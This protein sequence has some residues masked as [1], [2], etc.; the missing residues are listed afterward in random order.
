MLFV[1][2]P[3][4][5]LYLKKYLL[6]YFQTM[7]KTLLTLMAAFF[8]LQMAAQPK[9]YAWMR[10]DE[11][12]SNEKSLLKEFKEFKKRGIDGIC[13]NAGFD[14]LRTAIASRAAKKANL[15]YHAWMPAM[16]QPDCP[17]SWYAVNRLGEPANEHPAYVP[18]YKALDPANPEVGDFLCEQYRRIASI[19]TVDYV[20][21]DYIR[22]PDVVLSEGLWKKYGL[23]MNGEYPKAD[24]CYCDSC[25]AKFKRLTG[26]DIRQY[27]DPSKV[28][29]WAQFRCD[30][31]TA[32]VNRIAKT[33]H[34][35]TGKK[36]S[37]DVFPGPN[38]YARWMVRQEWQKW[39]VDML[40]P[41]N[42]NDFYVEPA[43][44]VGRVTKEEV[45]SVKGRNIPLISGIFICK[46]WRDKQNVIDPEYSGL[47]PS[48]IREAV[49]SSLK[50]GADGISIFTPQDM[51]PEHWEALKEVL[52][53]K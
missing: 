47:L 16:L 36:I 40:F 14:S 44:W 49:E 53:R 17:A 28:E 39:D 45:E 35:K 2:C 10:W 42:Y 24:Y 33:V 31:I 52:G 32:L 37:A 5:I 30:Q 34:E 25:V 8:A 15:E 50:A 29:A 3:S 1:A 43:G 46:D 12:T 38:S 27:T 20:Q 19:P 18:H 11:N 48:E 41:M 26:I 22:Y 13:L 6:I 9:V 21:L 51:T 4:S 7:K 23:V